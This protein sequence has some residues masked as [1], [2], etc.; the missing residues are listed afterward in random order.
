LI[1]ASEHI[2]V[3]E[4]ETIRFDKGEKRITRELYEALQLYYGKGVPYFRL[5][6]NG[7]QFCEYVGVIQVGK[8]VIEILPKADKNPNL[9]Q[10]EQKWRDVLIGMLRVIGVFDI[11]STSNSHLNIKSN[12]IL[13][14]YFE[15]F[16]KEV[17][18]LVHSGLVKQ[19]RKKQGN[20]TALKGSLQFGKHIQHNLVHKENFYVSHNTYDV[21]H[22]LHFILYKTICLIKQIN[23]NVSL[24]SRIG[25]L[26]LNFPEMP[27]VKVTESTFDKL[28]FNRKTQKYQNAVE[29]AKL[30]LL[31]YHPDI[32][33]GQNNVL[34]LMFDMN[35]LWE[36]FVYVSLRKVIGRENTITSQT[37]KSFWKPQNGNYSSIRPDIVINYD[38]E[39]CVVLD[40]KWKNLGGTKPSPDDLRQMYVYHEYFKAKKVALVYPSNMFNSIGGVFSRLNDNETFDKSCSVIGVGVG[41]NITIWQEE[42]AKYIKNWMDD[43][44]N[45]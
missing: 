32:S 9:G 18:H 17:E 43:K 31:K 38:S 26:L 42:I 41:D 39:Q 20:L 10:D 33:K 5:C 22:L 4:H 19:Y 28:V 13:D 23:T 30:L 25:S 2:T 44:S 3:F 12:T 11:H 21:D 7:I 1:K 14:L 34:A 35:V 37:T 15:L 29:I 8:T 36:R 45:N 16:L 40:T 27:D 24:Q 6:Y